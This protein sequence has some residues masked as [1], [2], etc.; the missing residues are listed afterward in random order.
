MLTNFSW[1]T[2]GGCYGSNCFPLHIFL[3]IGGLIYLFFYTVSLFEDKLT[4]YVGSKV[5]IVTGITVYIVAMVAAVKGIL[6]L[7]KL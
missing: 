6:F 5:A 1:L 7:N 4:K 2:L 3:I